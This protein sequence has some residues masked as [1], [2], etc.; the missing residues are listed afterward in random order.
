MFHIIEM[1]TWKRA[2][3][4]RHFIEE[5][6]N[7][8][9]VTATVDVT[10]LRTRCKRDGLRFCPVFLYVISR[11]VNRQPE[12]RMGWDAQG[13]VGIWDAVCPAYV[14]FHEQD[15][16]I[17]HMSTA[18]TSDFDAFYT[19]VIQTMAEHEQIR[20]FG[21]APLPPNHFDA[22]LVPW[23]DYQALNLHVFDAGNY[24]APVITGGKY[25][26]RE[27]RWCMPLSIQIHH[28][29]ADGY[30]VSRFF[31]DVQQEIDWL[32]PQS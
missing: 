6:R 12:L 31:V 2:P 22:S 9:A 16:L 30:H 18:Y 17:T 3:I 19:A 7:V 25:T 21:H 10:G 29:A 20:G 11:A 13:N 4:F 14:V 8:I 27:G 1:D 26:E 32:T 23:L 28:A 5:V 15:K 24:L